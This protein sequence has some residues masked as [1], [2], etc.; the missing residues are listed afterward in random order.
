[1]KEYA[2]FVTIGALGGFINGLFGAGAGMVLVPLLSSWGKLDYRNALA[3]SIA[4]VLP[5]SLASA[6]V[7]FFHGGLN[8]PQLL[9]YLLGGLTGG[10]IGG[11][12]FKK[13][14]L[15][16]IRRLFA[17]FIIYGGVRNLL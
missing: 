3:T 12:V 17:L 4:V 13:V 11:R 10:I 8:L 9:P 15:V 7:Y 1:M 16:W 2:K 14:P 6:A 5:M